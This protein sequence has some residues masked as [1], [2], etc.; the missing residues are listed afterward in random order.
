MEARRIC[1]HFL[2]DFFCANVHFEVKPSKVVGEEVESQY[3]IQRIMHRHARDGTAT[4][5][6][7][8]EIHPNISFSLCHHVPGIMRQ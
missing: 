7:L 4:P 8:I 5:G 3:W 1:I 6:H 2:R